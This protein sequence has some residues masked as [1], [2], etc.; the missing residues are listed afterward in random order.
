MNEIKRVVPVLLGH[1]ALGFIVCLAYTFSR[2]LTAD[3]I[4]PFMFSFRLR[5]AT[6]L[7]ISWIPA[8]HISG[9]L[10][11]YT[12]AFGSNADEDLGRWSETLLSYL[13]AAFFLCLF[14]IS[15]YVILAE[16]VSPFLEAR[17]EEAVARTDDYRDYLSVSRQSAF[18]GNFADSEFQSA[19]A[20]QIWKGSREATELH[21]Q[22]EY[23]L[24]S[25]DD[26]SS[27]SVG[28]GNKSVEASD[29]PGAPE[30]TVLEAL[31]LANDAMKDFDYYTT[32]YYAMMAYRLAPATDPNG[33]VALRLA[34]TAWN[35]ISEGLASIEM[36]GDR[37]LHETKQEGYDAIQ[38]GDFLSAYYVFL[39]LRRQEESSGVGKDPD[40]ER[41]LEVAKQGVLDS[42]F[43]MDET[44][45]MKRFESSRDVFFVL[46]RKDGSSDAVFM[47][48]V[49]WKRS[50]GRDMA[51]LRDLEYAHIGWD[52][53]LAYRI[54]VPYAKM[55]PYR[56]EDGLSRPE[57]LLH[58]VDRTRKGVETLPLVVSGEVPED[59]RNIIVLD[60]PYGDFNMI[61]EANRGVSSMTLVDL[62]GFAPKA[63]TYGFSRKAIWCEIIDRL[64]D[65]FLMLILSVYALVFAW[66]FKLG[67]NVMFKAW[68]VLILPLFPLIS[69]FIMDLLR[70]ITRLS[71][72][73]V[74]RAVPQNP[75]LII[76][77]LLAAWFAAASVYF[78]SQRSD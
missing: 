31:D 36:E 59:E 75:F 20:L 50:G 35:R 23:R 57:I 16:G 1:F 25:S 41:F 70:Y 74:V 6:L 12:L 3:V 69:V 14:F 56:D 37:L 58:A 10:I 8:L 66:R 7:F 33:Q 24:A 52:K 15:V 40:V 44:G 77:I 27:S 11:G 34:S 65:P 68:W 38:R 72:V 43:F 22:S 73:A 39:E 62:F 49:S 54:S 42:F 45:N 78:F 61:V 4:E 71:T 29:L 19:S 48:G 67:K 18:E 76:L 53:K 60:M 9:L 55:F 47:R 51:Y 32:H 2:P 63:S 13:K 21:E 17:Q 30:L 64:V 46:L 5:G 26:S 28:S